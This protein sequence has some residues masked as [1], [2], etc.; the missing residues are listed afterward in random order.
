MGNEVTKERFSA[1]VEHILPKRFNRKQIDQAWENLILH[2]EDASKAVMNFLKALEHIRYR[3]ETKLAARVAKH[4][5][6]SNS[7]PN[8]EKVLN[9]TATAGGE[10]QDGCYVRNLSPKKATFA[11]LGLIFDKLRKILKSRRISTITE[12]FN[13]H[14]KTNL[15]EFKNAILKMGMTTREINKMYQAI[16]VDDFSGKIDLNIITKKF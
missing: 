12:L 3:A 7:D 9:L 11:Q 4:L 14:T 1:T 5:T 15:I 10:D 6:R 2:T 13:G 16:T 8:I